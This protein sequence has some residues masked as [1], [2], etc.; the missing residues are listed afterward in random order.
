M[1][2]RIHEVNGIVTQRKRQQNYSCCLNLYKLVQ[3]QRSYMG[4]EITDP[5]E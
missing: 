2:I 4:V 1:T 5:C 3:S